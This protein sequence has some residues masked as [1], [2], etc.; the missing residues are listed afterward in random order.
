MVEWA[1]KTPILMIKA[2]LLKPRSTMHVHLSSNS[3]CRNWQMKLSGR[4][5]PEAEHKC[6]FCARCFYKPEDRDQHEYSC[7]KRRPEEP[8]DPP[9]ARPREIKKAEKPQKKEKDG[10]W[11]RVT[12]RDGVNGLQK[13][14]L[15]QTS[16]CGQCQAEQT[17]LRQCGQENKRSAPR[18]RFRVLF[19]SHE[20]FCGTPPNLLVFGVHAAR[21]SVPPVSLRCPSRPVGCGSSLLFVGPF[22]HRSAPFRCSPAPVPTLS[23]HSHFYRKYCT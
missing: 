3:G 11:S 9:R 8:A 6:T 18:I 4:K 14:I 7:G 5:V 20:G 10:S 1:P 23:R 19:V 12:W 13:G 2:W 16:S 17:R 15:P 21:G 22:R